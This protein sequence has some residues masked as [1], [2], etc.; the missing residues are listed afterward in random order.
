MKSPWTLEDSRLVLTI[1]PCLRLASPAARLFPVAIFAIQEVV[2][3]QS[4]P[5]PTLP[6][7]SLGLESSQL[8]LP[9]LCRPGSIKSLRIYQKIL[10]L[11]CLGLP[12]HTLDFFSYS[13]LA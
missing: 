4:L 9:P 6:P 1:N 7:S 5:N 13:K 2:Q 11:L 12:P 8:A 3:A 10:R